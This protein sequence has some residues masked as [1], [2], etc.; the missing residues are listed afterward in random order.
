METQA[1]LD[2]AKRCGLITEAEYG[3]LATEWQT[4]GRMLMR[5]IQQAPRFRGR[6]GPGG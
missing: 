6:G 5:M 3:E 4:I 2:Q 1:W